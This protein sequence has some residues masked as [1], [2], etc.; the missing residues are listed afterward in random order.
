MT[1]SDDVLQH[2]SMHQQYPVPLGFWPF[3]ESAPATVPASVATL[4]G[5]AFQPL[6]AEVGAVQEVLPMIENNRGLSP[7]GKAEQKVQLAAR[8]I[9]QL[10]TRLEAALAPAKARLGELD[11][12]LNRKALAKPEAATYELASLSA[13]WAALQAMTPEQRQIAVLQAEASDDEATMRAVALAP[14]IAR[15]AD[16]GQLERIQARLRT[17]VDPAA[18][19]EYEQLT[20]AIQTVERNYTSVATWL[21]GLA[22]GRR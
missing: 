1:T 13:S 11:G 4:N 17:L 10:Q 18:A 6:L 15:L 8:T 7:E 14:S 12:G 2:P 20:V 3:D 19:A 9:G 5:K 21:Q 16:A 22:A